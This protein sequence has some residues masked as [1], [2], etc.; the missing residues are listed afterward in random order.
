MELTSWQLGLSVSTYEFSLATGHN[1]GIRSELLCS[2][3]S[4]YTH[5]VNNQ[6]KL[7]TETMLSMKE[8]RKGAL[9][10]IFGGERNNCFTNN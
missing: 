5:Q 3:H 6:S 8:W 2:L 7:Q 9:T 10:V 4:A 1:V